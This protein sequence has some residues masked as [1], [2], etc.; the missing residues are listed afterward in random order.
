MG[1][2]KKMSKKYNS[3]EASIRAI[4][5]PMALPLTLAEDGHT[6]VASALNGVKVARSA[7]DKMETELG[8]MT[9]EG[10]LPS[11]WTNKVAIA[12]DKL[13]GMADYLDTQVEV[14]DKED[15]PKVK[16][17]VKKL[18]GASKAHAGQADDLEK[19]IKSERVTDVDV[20]QAKRDLKHA[21]IKKKISDVK[22]EEVE[23][24]EAIPKSTMYGVVVNGK[25]IAKGSKSDMT[26]LAK[27]KGGQVV[28]APGAK[29]GDKEGKAEE[30]ELDE[31]EFG[32]F[33]DNARLYGGGDEIYV[34]TQGKDASGGRGEHQ[35][36]V[37]GIAKDP[38]KAK[39]IRDA[40][41]KQNPKA[42]ARIYGQ[43]KRSQ[44]TFKLKV[45][46]PVSFEDS[47]NKLSFIEE[48]DLD[49]AIPKD[50]TYGVV[51]NGKYIA[52]GSKSDMRS[53]AKKKGGQLVNAPG[54]KVGDKEGKAEEAELDEDA[55]MAKQSDDNLKSLMKKIRDAEKK[56]PKMPSTQ[57]MIKRISK[58]MKKRGLKEEIDLDEAKSSTGY[59]LYHK[60]FSSA[61]Q[62][63]YSFAKKKYGITVDKKEIDDKVATGPKKPSKDKTNKYRLLGTDGKKAVQI[64]VTNLD[65]KRFE[66]NMYKEE[67]L[68]A[69][70]SDSS[71]CVSIDEESRAQIVIHALKDSLQEVENC[72]S[73]KLPAADCECDKQM[74]ESFIEDLHADKIKTITNKIT[75]WK[76]R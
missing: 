46:D 66:L 44:K 4:S 73:C 33:Q 63:A 6:D 32:K 19:A 51:V 9:P 54:A 12:V 39:K 47:K 58:E 50:T 14:L 59:E 57:H 7:L 31:D 28:N 23:L 37:V 49:E 76:T 41:N 52:K 15:E 25:Y 55:K 24:D 70:E 5:N 64:Q 17:I 27:K 42:K 40:A 18:K 21:K 69:Y 68:P 10:E 60:D 35:Q 48:V 16:E 67:V 20:D 29:V 8:K 2:G 71:E 65:G 11:W 45:G 74:Y 53:L 56:D 36:K 3:L 62:H 22:K 30:A 43:M 61:M 1:K 26:S 75:A 34:V 38:N 13:D 72:E